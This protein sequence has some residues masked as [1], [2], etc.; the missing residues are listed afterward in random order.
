MMQDQPNKLVYLFLIVL[1]LLSIITSVLYY[2]NLRD[3][4]Q[5]EV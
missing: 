4:S 3:D 5:E 2:L 1:A